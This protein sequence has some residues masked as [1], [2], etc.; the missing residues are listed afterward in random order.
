MSYDPDFNDPTKILRGD[1]DT[2][3]TANGNLFFALNDHLRQTCKPP[4]K[5]RHAPVNVP[6]GRERVTALLDAWNSFKR[7][8]RDYRLFEHGDYVDAAFRCQCIPDID[9]LLIDEFQDLAPLEYRL[10]KLWRDAGDIDTIYIAGDAG[11]SIYSFRGG[12]PHYFEHTDVDE[13]DTLKTSFRCKST[14]A[15]RANR[16]LDS[17]PDTNARGFAGSDSGGTAAWPKISD[18]YTLRDAIIESAERYVDTSPSV[19][20]LTR[21]RRQLG[22]LIG[23]LKNVGIPFE[24][25]GRDDDVYSRDMRQ[26]LAF[27]SNYQGDRSTFAASNVQTVLQALPDGTDRRKALSSGVI[28]FYDY[29]DMNAAF[30]DMPSAGEIL[31]R[32]D[33][34]TWQRD[35]LRTA[36]DAPA[37]LSPQDVHVGTIHRAKGLEAASVYL[38]VETTSKQVKR[39]HR[40]PDIAAEEHRIYYVG[41]T[42]ASDELN[43]VQGYFGGPEAP[44]LKQLRTTRQTAVVS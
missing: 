7:T 13:T 2:D 33:I 3:V 28:G 36:L 10:Y 40:N 8:Y 24:V 4:E 27:L 41:T 39:Y 17:H 16:L 34:D 14:I 11:Q 35:I 42:R 20:L 43:Y 32:M 6:M 29:E 26:W 18:P 31:D 19:F 9:V 22:K 30:S 38:F 1:T 15:E 23:D 44:P 37:A 21:T 5:Y 25:L 12:T